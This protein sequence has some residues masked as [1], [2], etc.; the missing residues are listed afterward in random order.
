MQEDGVRF[1]SPGEARRS[2]EAGDRGGARPR[3]GGFRGLSAAAGGEPLSP[4]AAGGFQGHESRRSPLGR[5]VGSPS[6]LSGTLHLLSCVPWGVVEEGGRA[7]RNPL[8][9][10]QSLRPWCWQVCDCCCRKA[11]LCARVCL[12]PRS[13]VSTSCDPLRDSRTRLLPQNPVEAWRQEG[14]VC[15]F[16]RAV[17]PEQGWG[18][19]PAGRAGSHVGSGCCRALRREMRALM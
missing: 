15:A 2:G 1:P 7:D 9:P 19:G 16:C 12:G 4:A 10:Q 17:G 14:R 6:G 5:R 11:R 13:E 3:P 18:R 8:S